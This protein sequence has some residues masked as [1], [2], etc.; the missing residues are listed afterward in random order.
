VLELTEALKLPYHH[1]P[2]RPGDIERSA[3]DPERA[4]AELAWT[5]HTKLEEGLEQTLRA[6]PR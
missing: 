2:P 3:L 5:A 4:R 6:A 1:A